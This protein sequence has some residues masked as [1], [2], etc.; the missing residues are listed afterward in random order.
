M[1]TAFNP[2]PQQRLRLRRAAV[3]A[4]LV[5]ALVCVQSLGLWHR[6]VHPGP[7]QRVGMDTVYAS[8]VDA[9][10]VPGLFTK[11]FAEHHGDPDC[12]YLD[13]ASLGDA[14][15]AAGTVAVALAM[16]PCLVAASHGLFI[17]RCHAL[18]HARGPP[19][20]R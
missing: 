20:V 17:A 2:V 13:H 18:F 1:S 7:G 14:I 5:F 15:G 16:A 6:L 3:A 9:A 4:L 11:P 12:Q 8:V 10:P 19:F